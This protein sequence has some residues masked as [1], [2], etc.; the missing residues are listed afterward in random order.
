LFI[1]YSVH[2]PVPGDEGAL[3]ESMHSFGELMGAQQGCVF[4]APYPFHAPEAGTLM[5]VSVWE[6]EAAFQ[7]ASDAMHEARRTSKSRDFELRPAEV[8]FL[9]SI[10]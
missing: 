5:G 1:F 7:S 6:T 10:R 2:F 3:A 9:N 8:H 4:V